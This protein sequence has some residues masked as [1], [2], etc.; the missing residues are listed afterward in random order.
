LNCEY[1]MTDRICLPLFRVV[2]CTVIKTE[3]L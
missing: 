3:R 2:I 1:R